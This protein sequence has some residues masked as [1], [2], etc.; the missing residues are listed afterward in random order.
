MTVDEK[1]CSTNVKCVYL[2]FESKFFKSRENT[3]IF[4]RP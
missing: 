2:K 3:K 4:Y 1:R